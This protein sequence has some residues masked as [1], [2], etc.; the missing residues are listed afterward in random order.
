M[1]F[2]I[3]MCGEGLGHTGRCIAVGKEL[4]A[5]GHEVYF[6]AYGYSK[7]LIEKE[8]YE[9][10]RIP[11]E[12]RLVGNSGTFDLK[13]SIKSTVSAVDIAGVS[14]IFKLLK[15]SRPDAVVS[16]GY[17]LGILAAHLKNI[18]AYIIVNQSNMVE[19]FQEK[20]FFMSLLGR[21]TKIF[22][23]KV[24]GIVYTIIVPD[25]PFPYTI[26]RNN[27]SFSRKVQH[28]INYSGPIIRKGPKKATA[29]ELAH[30]HVL[31]TI[32][33]FGYRLPILQKVISTAKLDKDIH[34]T[35]VTGPN[36]GPGQLAEVPENVEV[37]DFIADPFSYYNSTD[38]VIS[39]CGHG[40]TMET[41]SYGVPILAFPDRG[42]K[43]QENN[44]QLI[45]EMG[46]GKKM[47]YEVSAD[48]LLRSIREVLDSSTI[49]ENTKMLKKMASELEGAV[50]MRKLLEKDLQ[51]RTVPNDGDMPL[52]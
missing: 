30:P 16:D 17:Y 44:A 40:T 51:V 43:E 33:G 35:I 23:D 2:L 7:E 3:F 9:V 42:Q 52:S 28:K 21:L 37:Q 10:Y 25:F 20:G 36:I 18:P 19:Y 1:I 49:K 31:C 48:S 27:L 13:E 5:A 50:F 39:A 38:I 14:H 6:G 24:Y 46:Y 45:D 47:E 41:L 34:Y 29:K 26:C 32:G 8:G 12:F 4:L 22:Y 15:N 11:Q